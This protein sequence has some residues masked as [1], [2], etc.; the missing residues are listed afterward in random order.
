ML[1]SPED[2]EGQNARLAAP[3]FSTRTTNAS[4]S[5]SNRLFLDGLGALHVA[6]KAR[7]RLSL[8]VHG[9]LQQ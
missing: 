3:R 4:R 6:G 1:G 7:Q 8:R 2:R 9:T 5:Q